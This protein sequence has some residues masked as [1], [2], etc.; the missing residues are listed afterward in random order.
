MELGLLVV[1]AQ[2]CD[3]RG[4]KMGV[5]TIAPN[6]QAELDMASG[7][8]Q[9]VVAEITLGGAVLVVGPKENAAR[10]QRNDDQRQPRQREQPPR[11]HPSTG[12]CA[13]QQTERVEDETGWSAPG[14]RRCGCSA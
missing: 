12:R 1:G 6:T 2:A 4:E 14:V 11:R 3:A 9:M 8:G 7:F 5:G 13:C 10:D